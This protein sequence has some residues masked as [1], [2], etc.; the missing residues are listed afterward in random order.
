[1]PGLEAGTASSLRCKRGVAGSYEVKLMVIPL[2]YQY[3]LNS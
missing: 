3:Y 2:Y 1:M